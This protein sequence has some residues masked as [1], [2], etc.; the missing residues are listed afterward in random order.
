MRPTTRPKA[1]KSLTPVTPEPTRREQNKQDK[2]E[3]IIEAAWALF[4][5]R[6]IDGTTTAEVA[7]RAGI[8]KGTLFLYASDKDDLVQLLMHDRL[9]R[10]ATEAIAKAGRKRGLVAQWLFV[11]GELYRLYAACGPVGRRFIEVLPSARGPNSGRVA[12]L[13]M[14]FSLR[15]AAMVAEAQARGEVARDVDPMQAAMAAFGLYFF[16]LTA[17][18]Q[19]Y[20]EPEDVRDGALAQALGLLMRGLEA[21]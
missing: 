12:S 21:R 14:A 10:A 17:W 11:F 4:A 1:A 3:R 18:L 2:R 5:E 7:A 9:E 15:L 13:T 16:G 6:G 20:G 19:G 8:A